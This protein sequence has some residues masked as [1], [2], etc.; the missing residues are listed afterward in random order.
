M[1]TLP[2]W[3]VLCTLIGAAILSYIF[4]FKQG[5]GLFLVLGAVFEIGFWLKLFKKPEK[6]SVN[7][8][9]K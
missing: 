7:I 5:L 4:G 9:L 6:E 3:L 1:N 8:P 2:R